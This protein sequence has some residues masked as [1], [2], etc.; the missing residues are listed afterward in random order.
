MRESPVFDWI[1]PYLKQQGL[2]N[3]EDLLAPENYQFAL[4]CLD[5]ETWSSFIRQSIVSGNTPLST[6][7]QLVDS[8]EKALHDGADFHDLVKKLGG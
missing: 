5:K 6:G 2:P 3:K 4:L 7:S 8:F 1:A